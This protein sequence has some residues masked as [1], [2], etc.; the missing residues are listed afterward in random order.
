MGA[1]ALVAQ[2]VVDDA[3]RFLDG[4]FCEREDEA[5]SGLLLHDLQTVTGSVS[6]DV[7][8]VWRQNAAD[9][10]SQIALK[11]QCCCNPFIGPATGKNLLYGLDDLPVLL[12]GQCFRF[13]FMSISCGKFVFSRR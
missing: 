8:K 6:D 5:L 3:Q 1:D 2:V 12:C 4:S 13:L 11:N 7:A 10:E 9:P